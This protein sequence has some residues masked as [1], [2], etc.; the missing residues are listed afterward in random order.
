[1]I[2]PT[3]GLKLWPS[4]ESFYQRGTTPNEIWY[5]LGDQNNT[6]FSTVTHSFGSLRATRFVVARTV[7]IDR[8]AFE[9]TTLAAS[10]VGRCGIYRATSLTNQYPSALVVDAGEVSTATT[11]VKA[12]TVATTLCPGVYWSCGLMGV[13]NPGVRRFAVG[14]SDHGLGVTPALTGLQTNLSSS[15]SYQALPA[16]FPAGATINAAASVV[17]L[18]AAMFSA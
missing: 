12:A 18:V 14:C 10:G 7:I 17:C 1:M 11:G 3:Q 4:V 9:V 8:L 2:P 15:L 13:A 6:A 5:A 16:T